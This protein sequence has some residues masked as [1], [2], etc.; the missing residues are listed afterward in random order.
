MTN[1]QQW[2]SLFKKWFE[3]LILDPG[4]SVSCVGDEHLE[5][6]A[7]YTVIIAHRQ[8]VFRYDPNQLASNRIACHEVCHLFFATIAKGTGHAFGELPETG[9]RIAERHLKDAEEE[10]VDDLARAFLRAYGEENV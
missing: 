9:R 10:A 5:Y 8:A 4:W 7:S 2:E 6:P 3:R 1:E